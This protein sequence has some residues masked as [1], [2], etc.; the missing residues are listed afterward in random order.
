M[1]TLIVGGAF[2]VTGALIMALALP[3]MHRKIAPNSVY[4][5]RVKATSAD[6]WVWYEANARNAKEMFAVGAV[7]AALTLALPLLGVRGDLYALILTA[8]LLI[9]LIGVAIRGW[10]LATRLLEQRGEARGE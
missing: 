3:L 6:E 1:E 4:G 10:Q 2:L 5:L 8:S 7:V 9:G